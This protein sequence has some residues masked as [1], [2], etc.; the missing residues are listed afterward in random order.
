[1]IIYILNFYS[2]IGIPKISHGLL[3][4][5]VKVIE[6]NIVIVKLTNEKID[7]ETFRIRLTEVK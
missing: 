5:H 7:S 3:D 1:M 4:L 2:I 6:T